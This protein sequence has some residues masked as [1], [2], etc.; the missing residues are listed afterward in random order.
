MIERINKEQCLKLSVFFK[1]FLS[2]WWLV[3]L[4]ISCINFFCN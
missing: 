4:Q 1:Y 2:L 3:L